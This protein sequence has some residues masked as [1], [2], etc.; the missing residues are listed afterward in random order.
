MIPLRQKYGIQTWVEIYGIYIYFIML[1]VSHMCL[2]FMVF[3]FVYLSIYF[4]MLCVF[5]V[6]LMPEEFREGV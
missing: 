1:S 5:H 3:L 6:C 2:E 4:V